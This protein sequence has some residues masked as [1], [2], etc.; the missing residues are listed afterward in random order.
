MAWGTKM[1]FKRLLLAQKVNEKTARK[2]LK[3]VIRFGNWQPAPFITQSLL[4]ERGPDYETILSR[5]QFILEPLLNFENLARSTWRT[6]GNVSMMRK[7]PEGRSVMVAN[8]QGDDGILQWGTYLAQFE[9]ACDLLLDVPKAND[10]LEALLSAITK[11]L[12][13]IDS[14]LVQLATTWNQ[15]HP[16]LA[17]FDLVSDRLS[18][19][20]RIDQW[21]PK[22]TG[23]RYDKSV[24]SWQ[25]YKRL[26]EFRNEWDQHNKRTVRVISLANLATVGTAFGP[27]VADVLFTLH[28]VSQRKVPIRIIRFKYFPGFY[29]S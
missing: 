2:C 6:R 23:S 8:T 13:S 21:I 9:S 26:R 28:I 27:G 12:A 22:I 19:S 15:S 1:A 18:A 4:E 20:E 7:L 24:Q 17:Q 16:D 3:E 11:G 25:E 5:A 29:V 10:A 14:F